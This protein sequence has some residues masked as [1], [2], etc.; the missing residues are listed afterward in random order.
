MDEIGLQ[1]L[2]YQVKR[3]LLAPNAEQRASD[4]DPLFII[5]Q[6]ELE[7]TVKAV[8]EGNGNIKLSV[9]SFAELNVGGDLARERGHVVR[10][11]LSPLLTKEQILE[12]LLNNPQSRERVQQK[13]RQA[14]IKGDAIL[15]GPPE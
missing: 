2:I 13:Q 9:L 8:K 10:V 3:E 1:D 6:V 11:T 12:D 4:P 15:A 5:E 7:I 14:M